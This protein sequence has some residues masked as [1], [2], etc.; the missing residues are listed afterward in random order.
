VKHL[1]LLLLALPAVA[2]VA[3]R[4]FPPPAP[5][6]PVPHLTDGRPDL[7]GVWNGQRAIS[8]DGPFM[9]PWVERLVAR[10]VTTSYADDLEAR[11][12]P[13]GAPHAAPYHTSLFWTPNLV[14]DTTGLNDN[15]WIDM[16]GH[17]HTKQMHLTERFHR[18]DYGNLEIQVHLDAGHK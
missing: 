12:L 18:R 17:P 13:G 2:Q 16:P 15:P 6:G 14:V 11:C 4:G 10:R 1:L 3:G 8:Q 7:T 9:L 5:A